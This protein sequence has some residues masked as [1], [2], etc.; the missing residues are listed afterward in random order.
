MR[1]EKFVYLLPTA[2]NNIA[3]RES[4]S[5]GTRNAQTLKAS[6]SGARILPPRLPPCE[7]R[8]ITS[9]V[10]AHRPPRFGGCGIPV[11]WMFDSLLGLRLF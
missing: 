8:T 10:S 4:L 7:G 5:S 1:I 6:N 11:Q 3:Q 9:P 2:T